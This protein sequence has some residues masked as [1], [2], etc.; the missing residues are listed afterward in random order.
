MI[1]EVGVLG[2]G[3][4]EIFD[5]SYGEGGILKFKG[6][7]FVLSFSLIKFVLDF[8][9]IIFIF[10]G[11]F[12]V[13]VFIGFCILNLVDLDFLFFFEVVSL[14]ILDFSVEVFRFVRFWFLFVSIEGEIFC[15]GFI[16][17]FLSLFLSDD[18]FFFLF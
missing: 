6:E 17:D 11:F 14:D 15:E 4:F 5:I 9:S 12:M 3:V 1:I 2:S 10:E 8:S 13:G 7:F 18:V 16:F